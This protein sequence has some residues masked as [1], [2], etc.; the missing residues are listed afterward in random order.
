MDAPRT[1]SEIME[2]EAHVEKQSDD[3]CRRRDAKSGETVVV[4]WD[5]IR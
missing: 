1:A 2:M 4:G 3:A 5:E